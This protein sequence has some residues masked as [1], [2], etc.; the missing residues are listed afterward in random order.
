MEL[1]DSDYEMLENVVLVLE[2]LKCNTSVSNL[3]MIIRKIKNVE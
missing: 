3:K 1:N 2:H